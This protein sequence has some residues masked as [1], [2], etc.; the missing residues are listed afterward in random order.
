MSLDIGYG[1]VWEYTWRFI[2]LLVHLA[3]RHIFWPFPQQRR[4][5]PAR[6]EALSGCFGFLDGSE[7]PC[8]ANQV[9]HETGAYTGQSSSRNSRT[10]GG[11]ECRCDGVYGGAGG[12]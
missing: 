1:A 9:N 2:R 11:N 3:R 10:R 5:L 6:Q 8:K 12:G 4:R 7:I